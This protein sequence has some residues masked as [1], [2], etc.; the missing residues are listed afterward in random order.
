VNLRETNVT[1][2]ELEKRYMIKVL[3]DT[4]WHKKKAAEILGINPSTLYRKIKT[5]GLVQPG[6]EGA[7]DFDGADEEAVEI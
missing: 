2:E 4:S 7:E 6:E 3:S 1:L 5:Y